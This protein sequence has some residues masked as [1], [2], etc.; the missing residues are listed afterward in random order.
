MTEYLMYVIGLLPF[1]IVMAILGYNGFTW[2]LWVV[3]VT[4]MFYAIMFRMA[5]N[6]RETQY[7][8]LKYIE[9]MRT[10]PILTVPSN[11]LLDEIEEESA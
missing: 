3:F 10:Q 9:F 4:V 8:R 5:F 11:V 1:M 6:Y 2:Q 7:A